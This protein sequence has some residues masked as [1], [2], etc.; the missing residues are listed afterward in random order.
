M[1]R[2]NLHRVSYTIKTQIPSFLQ[3][4]ARH[5]QSL[6][7]TEKRAE[8][9]MSTPTYVRKLSRKFGKI[10]LAVHKQNA[11][12]LSFRTYN[13]GSTIERVY[14]LPEMKSTTS[15][16][17]FEFAPADRM[18]TNLSYLL[19]FL[20]FLCRQ[21]LCQSLKAWSQFYRRGYEGFFT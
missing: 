2:M 11:L 6:R 12:S 4:H 8:Y 20:L 19:V 13:S 18:V 3:H 17:S 9:S 14:K 10:V 21:R 1:T 5:R 15:A 7:L 16:P